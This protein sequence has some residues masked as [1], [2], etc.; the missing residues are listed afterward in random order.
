MEK[1]WCF[2]MYDL[3]LGSTIV[4]TALFVCF[5]LW[6]RYYKALVRNL[7]KQIRN[8]E[9]SH[10]KELSQVTFQVQEEERFRLG[11]NLHDDL[12][13][14][15][16]GL[17]LNL[18]MLPQDYRSGADFNEHKI[19]CKL[20][21]DTIIRKVRA[22]SHNLSPVNLELYGLAA[23]VE[24]LAEAFTLSGKLEINIQNEAEEMIQ[25]IQPSTAL[26]LFRVLEELLTNTI[27][28]AEAKKV[29]ISFA[30]SNA[31]LIILY[32]DDGKGMDKACVK[33]LGLYTINNRLHSI[34]ANYDIITSPDKGF[35]IEINCA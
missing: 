8:Q 20:L 15:L 23:A 28:H 27:R 3:L 5:Y 31:S 21:I 17:K 9:A 13:N 22:I 12:G 11:Q 35:L 14:S 30:R 18:D 16:A 34:N 29:L 1:E 6:S 33:G 2:G 25:S 26:S 7:K 24:D 19:T 4:I 32:K 10:R